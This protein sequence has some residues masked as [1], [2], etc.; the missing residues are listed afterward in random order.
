[1]NAQVFPLNF[2]YSILVRAIQATRRPEK[3]DKPNRNQPVMAEFDLAVGDRS[4]LSEID[5]GESNGGFRPLKQGP[6][7]PPDKR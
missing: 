3:T 4:Q 6:P 2:T 7:N 5:S 1:M